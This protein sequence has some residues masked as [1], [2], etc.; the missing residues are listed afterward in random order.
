MARGGA[1]DKTV[2]AAWRQTGGRGRLGRSFESPEGG[3]YLSIL[4]RPDMTPENAAKLSCAGALA[5]CRAVEKQCNISP[6]IK[7]P[8]DLLLG[9]KKLCGILCEGNWSNATDGYIVLGLGINVGT[10]CFPGTLGDTATS[11]YLYSGKNYDLKAMLDEIIFQL[12]YVY[13]QWG[14]DGA[15]F[16]DEYRRRCIT[17]GRQVLIDHDGQRLQAK[18]ISISDSYGL[19]ILWPDGRT[20]EKSYG[21]ILQLV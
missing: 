21:E 6:D 13:S 7:W 12:D 19:N 4:W 1:G 20:E 9:G 18:A 5:V 8:N 11:L 2:L 3:I 16:I 14:K 17:P 15:A 10:R